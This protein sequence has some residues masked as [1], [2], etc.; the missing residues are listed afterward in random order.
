[1]NVSAKLLALTLPLVLSGCAVIDRWT[2]PT[3]AVEV[4]EY[5]RS[6][7]CESADMVPQVTYLPTR[8]AVAAWQSQR[9]VDL[10][11]KGELPPSAYAVVEM[12]Q[13]GTSGYGIAVSRA[14]TLRKGWLTLRATFVTPGSEAIVADA[15]SSPCVLVSLPAGDWLGVMVLDQAGTLR[16]S[17]TIARNP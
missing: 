13:H 10:R 5:G 11:M 15:L 8:D 1:M 7:Q 6:Q 3:V 12:G 2:Y 17:A 14:A 4:E 16:A 9:T